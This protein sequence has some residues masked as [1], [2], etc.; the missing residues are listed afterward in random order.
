MLLLALSVGRPVTVEEGETVRLLS[1]MLSQDGY[2]TVKVPHRGASRRGGRH[3]SEGSRDRSTKFLRP[4]LDLAGARNARV[5][6]VAVVAVK[7]QRT[8]VAQ[9]QDW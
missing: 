4:R 8:E 3:G 2:S 6:H 1:E 7:G 9:F 5:S